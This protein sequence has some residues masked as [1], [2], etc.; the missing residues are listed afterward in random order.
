MG[1]SRR[2]EVKFDTFYD[3]H[4]GRIIESSSARTPTAQLI[5]TTM[6]DSSRITT[7]ESYHDGSGSDERTA[8]KN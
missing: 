1:S 6:V 3:P 5:T 8:V 2:L 7:T 4:S